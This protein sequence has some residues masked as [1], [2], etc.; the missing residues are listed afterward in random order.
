MIF[1]LQIADIMVTLVI[2]ASKDTS[3]IIRSTQIVRYHR[4]FVSPIPRQ[5]IEYIKVLMLTDIYFLCRERTLVFSGTVK[6]SV[7][8][9]P[10]FVLPC[11]EIERAE[12]RDF[13]AWFVQQP[14]DYIQI[15]TGFGDNDRRRLFG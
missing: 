3:S 2:P 8:C 6:T 13:F 7:G 10:G 15:M 12:S 14:S 11:K 9:S 5:V 4:I 1:K